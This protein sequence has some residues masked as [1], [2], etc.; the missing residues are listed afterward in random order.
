VYYDYNVYAIV[1]LEEDLAG[2]EIVANENGGK[3]YRG[4]GY[5]VIRA[6]DTKAGV[7]SFVV[8]GNVSYGSG[9]DSDMKRLQLVG[10]NTIVVRDGLGNETSVDI[11]DIEEDSDVPQANIRYI[12]D[13]NRYE[14]DMS[15]TKG[16]LWKIVRNSNEE[17]VD[18]T[19]DM[20]PEEASLVLDD[21]VG[22]K[23]LEVYD[24]LGNV[25]EINLDDV[26]CI[27]R[28]IYKN[29]NDNKLAINV[30]DVRGVK[31]V[32]IE[33]NDREKVIERYSTPPNKV[34]K[35][36][37]TPE[38]LD[39]VRIYSGNNKMMR[40]DDVETYEV[41][42]TVD[43]SSV[44]SLVGIHTLEYAD[45]VV[46]EFKQDMPTCVDVDLV[47][48]NNVLVSDALDNSVVMRR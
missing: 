42:L 2:V 40:W 5:V 19:D 28:Y 32:A 13:D 8:G 23:S 6:V 18:Y 36:Y 16:G 39:A 41:P 35:C 43:G 7:D 30:E 25:M 21:I 48:H 26:L 46:V 24:S 45:G 37:S 11:G 3:F 31:K 17:L 20:Y 14:I 27:V 22:V 4:N 1:P 12:R 47:N 15:D 33:K 9:E 10:A 44:Y 38:G 29:R 34:R